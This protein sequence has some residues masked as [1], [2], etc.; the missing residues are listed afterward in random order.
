MLLLLV[1]TPPDSNRACTGLKPDRGGSAIS[2]LADERHVGGGEVSEYLGI[3][4]L[5]TSGEVLGLGLEMSSRPGW[6][7]A[8]RRSA[9][10]VLG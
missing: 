2:T 6:G 10:F 4:C 9:G 5:E 7:L 8:L 3:L 1:L